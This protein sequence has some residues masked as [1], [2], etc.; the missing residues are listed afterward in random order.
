[1]REAAVSNDTSEPI[2]VGCQPAARDKRQRGPLHEIVPQT[3][4]FVTSYRVSQRYLKSKMYIDCETSRFIALRF[5]E[6]D[7]LSCCC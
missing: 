5:C 7:P 6:G 1:M 2:I 4:S 3:L